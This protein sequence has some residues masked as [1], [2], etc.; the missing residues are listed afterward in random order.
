M[1]IYVNSWNFIE[2]A[3]EKEKKKDFFKK[4]NL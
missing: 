1:V 3:V 2:V 4:S